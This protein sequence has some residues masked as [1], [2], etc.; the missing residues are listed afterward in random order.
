[1]PL[2]TARAEPVWGPERGRHGRAPAGFGSRV[3]IPAGPISDERTA[4]EHEPQGPL[5]AQAAGQCRLEL[6]ERA[7]RAEEAAEVASAVVLLEVDA[8]QEREIALGEGLERRAHLGEPVAALPQAARR[9]VDPVDDGLPFQSR[10]S[11][12]R[13]I[14]PGSRSGASA[15]SG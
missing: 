7:D 12:K 14:A 15:R 2:A 11:R 5:R 4:V 1:M 9:A 13:V 6:G 10:P 3:P 8:G